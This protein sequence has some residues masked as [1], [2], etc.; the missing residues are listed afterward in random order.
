MADLKRIH[1]IDFAKGIAIIFIV[2][3]HDII[4]I[5]E[6]SDT[7]IFL[8]N[9][10]YEARMP[11]F[12]IMAGYLL[13][14]IKWEGREKDFVIKL[15][16]RLL[17]PFYVTEFLFYP[18]WLVAG[19]WMGHE[20]YIRN[21]A[22]TPT[23]AFFGIFWGNGNLLTLVPLWF[24]ISLFWAEIIYLLLHGVLKKIDEKIFY[25][26][27]LTLTVAGYLISKHFWL[28]F[29]FDV[30]M[31]AQ[32]FLLVGALIKKYDL[33]NR[34][35]WKIY[36]A[37]IVVCLIICKLNGKISMNGRNYGNLIFMYIGG[38]SGTLLQ[39]KFADFFSRFR[40][41]VSEFIEYCG[42][43]S[44]MI[45][46][47]HLPVAFVMYDIG[48]AL[49][50]MTVKIVRGEPLMIIGTMIAGIVLPVVIAKLFGDKPVVK[51]FCV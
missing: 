6:R 51:Y 14:T 32:L 5:R 31:T 33:V 7:V 34:I 15:F 40:G 4:Y 29:G 10:M 50:G 1:W 16:K 46:V 47:L 41:I 39:M 36:L 23:D 9:L 20:A 19:H 44:L 49:T 25:A 8:Y 12:F 48:A 27:I 24:F 35:D 18:I 17:I 37:L 11:F 38:V 13:N 22:L 45:L 30:A 21:A 28:P 3:G 42:K 26:A 43:Q 2:I